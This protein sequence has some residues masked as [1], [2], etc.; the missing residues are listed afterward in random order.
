MLKRLLAVILVSLAWPAVPALA[1]EGNPVTAGSLGPKFR[2][3]MGFASP[4]P[5]PPF[6]RTKAFARTGPSG[7]PASHFSANSDFQLFDLSSDPSRLSSHSIAKDRDRLV[8]DFGLLSGHL[9]DSSTDRWGR[10]TER[11]LAAFGL[12]IINLE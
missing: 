3:R 4:A 10:Q 8:P 7:E 1:Q 5:E 9:V 11:G 6:S 2:R 12:R